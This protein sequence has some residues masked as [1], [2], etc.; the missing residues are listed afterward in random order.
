MNQS[1]STFT[2]ISRMSC[3]MIF[4]FLLSWLISFYPFNDLYDVSGSL[5]G[6]DYSDRYR[7][8]KMY[9]SDPSSI[10]NINEQQLYL[11]HLFPRFKEG[12][13]YIFLLPP[14]VIIPFIPLSTIPYPYS[15]LVFS[16]IAIS[17][18][19]ISFHLLRRICTFI[20]T[21]NWHKT[22]PIFLSFP[23]LIETIISGQLSFFAAFIISG[24]TY[25]LLNGNFFFAGALLA[26]ASY[27][28]PILLFFIIAILLKF[29]KTIFSF[30][31]CQIIFLLASIVLVGWD[32]LLS[33]KETISLANQGT[34]DD[35]FPQHKF[36]SIKNGIEQLV[37]KNLSGIILAALGTFLT[38]YTTNKWRKIDSRSPETFLFL[39]I[40]LLINCIFNTY[41]P[42]Y[43]YIILLPVLFFYIE[44]CS[45]TKLFF[46][47][48]II[49]NSY[50]ILFFGP[51]ISQALF[52]II[53][54][55]LRFNFSSAIFYISHKTT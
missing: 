34:F 20:D 7:A 26:F 31:F 17:F 23:P 44:Y 54:F 36:F 53:N 24:S 18:I 1:I 15:F 55:P 52:K 16:L 46:S 25:L 37:P 8:G 38:L 11:E 45:T 42:I 32:G 14:F 13:G 21:L 10:Y 48:R 5:L 50:I 40:I 39:S 35:I 3:I 22:L 51:H 47:S 4:V 30:V 29:P 6:T 19:L 12:N 2:F 9:T 49:I 33:W 41:M 27:K 28:P 43:D